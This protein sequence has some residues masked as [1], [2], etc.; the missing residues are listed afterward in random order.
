MSLGEYL[1]CFKYTKKLVVD[2]LACLRSSAD[3]LSAIFG[4]Y[5]KFWTDIGVQKNF[6]RSSVSIH[7][8][9]DRHI[10]R[11]SIWGSSQTWK[12]QVMEL[13]VIFRMFSFFKYTKKLVVD[14]LACLGAS[15]DFISA[16]FGIYGKFWI[17]I[18]VQ[19]KFRRKIFRRK[20]IEKFWKIFDQPFLVENFPEKVTIFG[21]K[22]FRPNIFWSENFRSNIFN[23]FRKIS[24]WKIFRPKN[25]K[26]FSIFFDEHFSDEKFSEHL[27]RSKIS[28]RF[29][30]SHL[31]NQPMSLSR[32]KLQLR[33]FLYIWNKP[34]STEHHLVTS[35]EMHFHILNSLSIRR[36][37]PIAEILH[38]Q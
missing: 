29:Q 1:L 33:V 7:P 35:S 38:M 9:A 32:P 23:F 20:K 28:R 4:I 31:E 22:N 12:I 8:V 19:K 30:K 10:V 24:V 37:V 21:S 5:G 17:D 25:R 18:G 3:F 27:Y 2:V 16:I 36:P 13:N 26:T 11:S 6:R 15:A 34:V 14:V